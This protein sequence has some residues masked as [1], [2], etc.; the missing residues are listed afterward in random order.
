[1]SEWYQLTN[2][3]VPYHS[4]KGISNGPSGFMLQKPNLSAV[5]KT[6]GCQKH[7]DTCTDEL[8]GLFGPVATRPEK[9]KKSNQTDGP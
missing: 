7:Y 3:E 6:R 5:P 1:M 4:I 2:R 9:G 8:S